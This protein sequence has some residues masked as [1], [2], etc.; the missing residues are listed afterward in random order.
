MF[1]CGKQ[2]KTRH[3]HVQVSLKTGST[4]CLTITRILSGLF[5]ESV[6]VVPARPVRLPIALTDP[7]KFVCECKEEGVSYRT[8]GLQ[9]SR[10]N[11]I[12]TSTLLARHVARKGHQ[13][14]RKFGDCLR[15]TAAYSLASAI[16]LDRS[17]TLGALLGVGHQPITCLRIV[18]TLFLP[19]LDVTAG[20]G[21]VIVSK[22]ATVSHK[23]IQKPD[24][25]RRDDEI[26]IRFSPETKVVATSTVHDGDDLI[27]FASGGF[28]AK[29]GILAS[30]VWAP[31]ELRTIIDVGTIQ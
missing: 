13:I 8:F 30:G 4:L 14:S 15:Q 5:V 9:P 23:A 19:E 29:D 7:T 1:Q 6:T 3:T 24:E 21:L 17:V 26:H 31:F 28:L 22:P 2:T 25:L 12:R 27:Q 16:L 18:R 11:S 20:E 10:I